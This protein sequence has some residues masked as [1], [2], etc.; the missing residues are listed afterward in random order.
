[1]Y[2]GVDHF[3][4]NIKWKFDDSPDVD[5]DMQTLEQNLDRIRSVSHDKSFNT[6]GVKDEHMLEVEVN[7]VT[8]IDSDDNRD[9]NISREVSDE[10]SDYSAKNKFSRTSSLS[11]RDLD[12]IKESSRSSSDTEVTLTR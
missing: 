10:K 12:V 3:N 2:P 9:Y 8:D 7:D 6:F 4:S 11:N 1:M 5:D